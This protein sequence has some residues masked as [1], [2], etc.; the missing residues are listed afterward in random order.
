MIECENIFTVIVSKLQPAKS[1][2]FARGER[3]NVPESSCFL[4]LGAAIQKQFLPVNS[5]SF[6]LS[7]RFSSDPGFHWI[8]SLLFSPFY[9]LNIGLRFTSHLSQ[10][11]RER[12]RASAMTD[13]HR[14][15][16]R[17]R[18]LSGKIQCDFLAGWSHN[19]QIFHDCGSGIG[20]HFLNSL[21]PSH[22]CV[23]PVLMFAQDLSL[24]SSGREF[25]FRTKSSIIFL[26]AFG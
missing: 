24:V 1:W 22:S 23:I 11:E 7:S 12:E 17:A 15:R 2:G 16:K 10:R 21:T 3:E 14:R 25:E 19:E 26:R 5:I 20:N 13:P 6:E 4:S 9:F 8:S 18:F